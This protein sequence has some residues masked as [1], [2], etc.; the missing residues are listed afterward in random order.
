[1]HYNPLDNFYKSQIGAVCANKQIT[2]R[3]KGEFDSVVFVCRKDG[4]NTPSYYQMKKIDNYFEL[5][6]S[7]LRGLY[8]Y[9]FQISNSQ[10]ISA[11][12]DLQGEV[13][14][15]LKEFQLTA[16]DEN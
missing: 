15:T 5:N 4:E 6:I 7:F 9:Y 1:M 3:V 8:Y 2:F 13:T 11:N 10:F 14:C 12:D 16:Y